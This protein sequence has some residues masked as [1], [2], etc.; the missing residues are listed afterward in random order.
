[1]LTSL[2][3]DLEVVQERVASRDRALV[4]EGGAIGPVR[5]LLEETVPVLQFRSMSATL[6]LH[7]L[8]SSLTI[9]VDFNMLAS[10][11][12]STTLSLKLSP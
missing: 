12:S 5:A 6:G 4:H 10:V 8:I 2:V 1:M 11:R 3:R 9:E 7:S